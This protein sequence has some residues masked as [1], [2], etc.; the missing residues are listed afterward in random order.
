MLRQALVL[1]ARMNSLQ[2]SACCPCG[3][4]ETWFLLSYFFLYRIGIFM[5][6]KLILLLVQPPSRSNMN[7]N[8]GHATIDIKLAD[9]LSKKFKTLHHPSS[10]ECC[11][12]RVSQSQRCLNPSDYTP[13]IVSIGQLHH[14]NAELKAMEDN[15]LRYL[16]HFFQR[17]KVSMPEFVAFIREKEARL[18][19]CYADTI[20]LE[21]DELWPWF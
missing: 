16:H 7:S 15:K 13:Q 9:S 12:Y 11:I 6:H 21:S 17:T 19:N 2:A 10:E 3:F 8:K 4:N 5:F 1:F 18:R 20:H 14:G